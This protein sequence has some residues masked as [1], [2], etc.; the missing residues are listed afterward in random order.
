MR[1]KTSS[2]QAFH[3]AETSVLHGGDKIHLFER[4]PRRGHRGTH[5][6]AH[7]SEP[8]EF[9]GIVEILSTENVS[10]DDVVE[11]AGDGCLRGGLVRIDRDITDRESIGVEP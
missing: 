9:G 4:K 6:A 11:K 3:R 5:R 10:G 8:C 7:H 1:Q 2:L